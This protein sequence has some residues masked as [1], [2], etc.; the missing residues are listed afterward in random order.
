MHYCI[1]SL[2]PSPPANVTTPYLGAVRLVGGDH[3]TS[4]TVQLYARRKWAWL[5]GEGAGPTEANAVC[6]QLG[7]TAADSVR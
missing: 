5:C 7:Y 4:G 2:P 6:R 3:T 1:S